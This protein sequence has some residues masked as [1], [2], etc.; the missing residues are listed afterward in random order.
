MDRYFIIVV[1]DIDRKSEIG[2]WKH[3]IIP[4]LC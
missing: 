2:E 1:E 4:I 3:F